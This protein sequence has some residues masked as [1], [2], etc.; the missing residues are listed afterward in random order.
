MYYQGTELK[1]LV[2]LNCNI[3]RDGELVGPF[4]KLARPFG[5][6]N[7]ELKLSI[8][9]DMPCFLPFSLIHQLGSIR[10][11]YSSFIFFLKLMR[12]SRALDHLTKL[13]GLHKMY[14]SIEQKKLKI[15]LLTI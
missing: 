7:H 10:T 3:T 6:V 12:N 14:H 4:P 5:S 15:N 13:K 1:A 2:R 8:L 9:I 11:L